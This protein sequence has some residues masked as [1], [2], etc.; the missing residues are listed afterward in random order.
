MKV[1]SR[2]PDNAATVDQQAYSSFCMLTLGI[3]SHALE[4]LE[5]RFVPTI[6][7]KPE[8]SAEFRRTVAGVSLIRICTVSS[9]QQRRSQA[10]LNTSLLEETKHFNDYVATGR[11]HAP[12]HLALPHDERPAEQM[13][14]AFVEQHKQRQL[15]R[16]ESV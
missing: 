12:A 3:P 1:E 4:E 6:P 16:L 9:R 15:I 13:A 10:Q 14:R 2:D 11:C 8:A 7:G 5:I